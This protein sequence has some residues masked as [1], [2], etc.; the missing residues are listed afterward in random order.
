MGESMS[1]GVTTKVFHTSSNMPII[2]IHQS[3]KLFSLEE[4]V[5]IRERCARFPEFQPV[6]QSAVTDGSYEIGFA[7]QIPNS[8]PEEAVQLERLHFFGELRGAHS[9]GADLLQQIRQFSAD[10]ASCGAD[11]VFTA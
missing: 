2:I 6:L 11:T 7:G 3:S 1:Q 5:E 4:V 9:K 8:P 10:P